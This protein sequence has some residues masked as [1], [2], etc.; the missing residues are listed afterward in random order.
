MEDL[1]KVN[2]LRSL[3]QAIYYFR[4]SSQKQA[5]SEI[6]IAHYVARGE[7]A[8]FKPHQILYDVGSG[9]SIQRENYQVIL[10]KI[11][12]GEVNSIYL[13]NDL[14]RLLR[15]IAEFKK[16]QKLLIETGVQLFDLN[17]SEYKF[18]EPEQILISDVQMS[19][20][21]FERNRNRHKAIQGHKY[22][23]EHGKAM[24]AVFPYVKQ[25]GVLYPNKSEYKN[26]GKSVWEIGKEVIDVYIDCGSS[27]HTINRMAAKYGGD[28][29]GIKRWEDYSRTAAG[30]TRW[31]K[32]Q[33]IRG[34]LHYK[35]ADY[36]AYGTHNPLVDDQTLKTLNTLLA[37]SGQGRKVEREMQ[38]IWK[39][40]AFCQCGAPMRVHLIVRKRTNW[41]K[42][43]RYLVCSEAYTSNS[44]K[45]R[46]RR[47]GLEV[48][49]CNQA[50]T[51][52]LTVENME[53]LTINALIEKADD[54]AN[55]VFKEP[56]IVMSKEVEQLQAQIK[57]YKVLA[58][59]DEDLIPVLNK[60]QLQLNQLLEGHKSND[61]MELE[62]LR[63]SLASFGKDKEFWEQASKKEKLLLF[64]E[65][66]NTIICKEGKPEFIF[67]V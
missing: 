52:G 47:L 50:T 39:G 5:D 55:S 26:T 11:S 3:E 6:T 32:S 57:K 64:N 33:F 35:R 67:K 49:K 59:D 28:I 20:Y 63:K 51:Y 19:F 44:K 14:S 54:I 17:G 21:E 36:I 24:Q 46:K 29:N 22:L 56:K 37:I 40:I 12:K 34:N 2:S 31:L 23:R 53:D 61:E 13:P 18:E 9:G 60:K 42:K 66:I 10:R 48:V 43:Y 65:F 41:E 30:L 8:G 38:N 58:Q 7:K 15:D 25:N 4:M 16:L 1:S 62:Y 27:N 45:L